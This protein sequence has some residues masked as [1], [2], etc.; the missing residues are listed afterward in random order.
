MGGKGFSFSNHTTQDRMAFV[1]LGYLLFQEVV[2]SL[3]LLDLH[4]IATVLV[5]LVLGVLETMV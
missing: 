2:L 4:Q 1:Q 5:Y 3:E